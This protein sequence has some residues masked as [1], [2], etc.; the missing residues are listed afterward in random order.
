M[1]LAAEP[2]VPAAT[3]KISRSR[4]LALFC[5]HSSHLAYHRLFGNLAALD[6][7]LYDFLDS[8]PSHLTYRELESAVG[9][10]IALDLWNSYYFTGDPLEERDE[11]TQMLKERQAVLSTGRYLGAIQ[12]SSS[13]ACNY[14]C[15][16]C[17]ADASDHRSK[18]RESISN[19]AKNISFDLA[20]QAIRQVLRVARGH[21]RDRIAVKFLGRE[22]LVNWKVIYQ[23]FQEFDS[24]EVVWA[25]TTNGSLITAEIARALK[26]H[27]VLTIVSLDGPPQANDSLRVLKSGGGTYH[28]T[29]TGISLLAEAGVRFGISSVISRNTDMDAMKAFIVHL[30]DLG[31]AELELTL[32]MQTS[33]YQIQSSRDPDLIA[34]KLC[35]LYKYG[36]NRLFIHGDWIDP[37]YRILSTHKSRHEKEVNQ[38]MGAACTATS[39]QISLEPTGDLFPCRAMSTHYGNVADLDAALNSAA[40]SS[41]A[42][43]TFLNVP[44]CHGCDLE[45]FCQGTCLGSAEEESGDIY[46]PPSAYCE[47]YRATTR[48]LLEHVGPCP[49]L[50]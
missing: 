46:K 6:P 7:D 32:A 41:V 37:Y 25:I 45:G 34:D 40:Y 39:H 47:I 17:F 16:Y 5:S 21:G 24:G 50:P 12:I 2:Q 30:S 9:A 22:P 18:L 14:A 8:G 44:A 15:S 33:L 42:M 1:K 48:R 10:S 19:G 36:E 38:P 49:S 27:G 28:A 43:R 29:E 13:N 20:A 26:E 23:L 11:I 3:E 4:H 35:D 31:A